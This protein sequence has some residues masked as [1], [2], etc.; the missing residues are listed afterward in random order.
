M[1]EEGTPSRR[2]PVL[3]PERHGSV[4]PGGAALVAA[5]EHPPA[6]GEKAQGGCA[7]G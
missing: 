2:T 7:G 3:E 5:R 4:L 1:Q 6:S